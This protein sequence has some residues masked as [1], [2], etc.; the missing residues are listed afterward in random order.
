M[1]AYTCIA[2]TN[3]IRA[4]HMCVLEMYTHLIYYIF[5][6]SIVLLYIPSPILFPT[7]CNHISR[8][9]N[10]IKLNHVFLHAGIDGYSRLVTYLHC[11]SDNKAATVLDLFIH[12]VDTY[13]VPSRVRCDLGVENVDVGR[14]MLHHLGTDRSSYYHWPVSSQSKNRTSL[15]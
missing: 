7:A 12:A 14:W 3:P 5:S 1:N 10:N 8:R 6:V 9:H 15:A 13:G 4:H 11:S 2:C